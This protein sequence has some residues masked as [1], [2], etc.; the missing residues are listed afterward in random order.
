MLVQLIQLNLNKINSVKISFREKIC[1]TH[2]FFN[3]GF[4]HKCGILEQ[5]EFLTFDLQLKIIYYFV[6]VHLKLLT[7][8][9]NKN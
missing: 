7:Q 2:T 5:S 9:C 8:F 6:F 1:K 4:T 3:T